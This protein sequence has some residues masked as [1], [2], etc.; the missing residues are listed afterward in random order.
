MAAGVR[1]VILAEFTPYDPVAAAPVTVRACS[2]DDASVT[3]LN[4]VAWWP[5]I[6]QAPRRTIDLFDGEF[7]GRISAAIGDIEIATAAFPNAP[8]FSWGEQ[9]VKLWRG[10]LG[11]AWGSYTQIFQG[12]TRPARGAN[13]RL[14]IGLR[15]DD[16]WLDRPLLSTY[17]GTGNAEGPADLRGVPKPLALGTPQFIEGVLINRALNIYQLHGYGAMQGVTVALDRLNRYGAAAGNDANYAALAAATIAPGAWRTC[18]AEGLVRFGAP[19]AGVVTFLAQG[20]SGSALG[21]VRTPGQVIR[22]IALVAGATAGQINA[23]SLAALDTAVPFN[24]SRHLRDQTTAREVIQSIAASCNASAG[25]SHMGTLF[26]A[27]TVIGS[28]TLTLRADGAALPPVASV[29]LLE[30][31][32]P[33]W[34]VALDAVRTERV[35]SFAEFG[36]VDFADVGGVTKPDA[37]ATFGGERIGNPGLITDTAGWVLDPGITRVA[38]LSTDPGNYLQFATGAIRNALTNG[39]AAQPIGGGPL[40]WSVWTYRIAGASASMSAVFNW[41]KADGSAASTA[42][43]AISILPTAATVWQRQ[44]GKVTPPADAVSFRF[45]FSVSTTGAA[46]NI[47]VPSVSANEAGADITAAAQ[48][49]VTV[50]TTQAY[51]ATFAGVLIGTLQPISVRVARGGTSIKIADETTYSITTSPGITATINN[52]TGSAN[53]GDITPTALTASQATIEVTVTVAG[54]VQPTQTILFTRTNAPAPSAGG[55]GAK[56]ATDTSLLQV[57]GTSFVAVSDVMTVTVA[58]G[59]SIYGTAPVD[60]QVQGTSAAFTS[61]M[62]FKW[63]RSPAGAG[64]W[65]DFATAVTGSTST[66]TFN[67]GPPDYE[68]ADGILGTVSCNQSTSPGAGDYDVRLVA[69]ANTASRTLDLFNTVTVQARV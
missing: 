37:N 67:T 11:A 47:A 19:P 65:T 5:A 9:P 25:V 46:V 23:T 16:R 69:K 44:S 45:D 7:G 38:G 49:V 42:F 36:T 8:R 30:Q 68:W 26:V 61:S 3:S 15:V 40:F 17:A 32:A 12:L 35:H 28:P 43:T 62:D 39:A 6:S 24:I 21:W 31:S 20:D 27:R 58:S 54:V 33:F 50:P 34:R 13:G 4:G 60:Y 10:V 55:I 18:L 48:V 14:R 59:E 66:A 2:V 52:T 51:D 22:R 64:T 53:K 29:E 63:Q 1:N 57:T 41:L 56:T